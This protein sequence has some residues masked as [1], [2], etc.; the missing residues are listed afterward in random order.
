MQ[1]EIIWQQIEGVGLEHLRLTVGAEEIVADGALIAI[2]DGKPL[3][4]SI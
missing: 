2:E 4:P 1:H 3:A